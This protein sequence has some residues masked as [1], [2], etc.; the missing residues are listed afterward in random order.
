MPSRMC[1]GR[2]VRRATTLLSSPRVITERPG[3]EVHAPGL[4]LEGRGRDR[5]PAKPSGPVLAEEAPHSLSLRLINLPRLIYPEPQDAA[6]AVGLEAR[7]PHLLGSGRRW[8]GGLRGLGLGLQERPQPGQ[9]TS[10]DSRCA[11]S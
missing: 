11:R 7:K 1:G 4:G 2:S 3:Q 8:C 10:N 9:L 5:R 6:S